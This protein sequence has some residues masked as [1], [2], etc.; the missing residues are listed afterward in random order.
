MLADRYNP[1]NLSFMEEYLLHQ[2]REGGNDLLA[3]LAIL[4]LLVET[5]V[6]LI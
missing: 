5:L 6:C 1:T 3:N 4:K 2:V